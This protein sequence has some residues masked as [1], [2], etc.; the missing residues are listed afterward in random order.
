[1]KDTSELFKEMKNSIFRDLF[2]VT[3]DSKGTGFKIRIGDK[4]K[5]KAV[6]TK[7]DVLNIIYKNASDLQGLPGYA[8]FITVVNE[9]RNEKR[10]LFEEA[11][12]AKAGMIFDLY[13]SEKNNAI[14]EFRKSSMPKGFGT[15]L[16][17]TSLYPSATIN[18]VDLELTDGL[19]YCPKD[20]H[21]Y[22]KVKDNFIRIGTADELREKGSNPIMMLNSLLYEHLSEERGEP[23]DFWRFLYNIADRGTEDYFKIEAVLKEAIT[24]KMP[25][26]GIEVQTFWMK[27]PIELREF[28]K[29]PDTPLPLDYTGR[30]HS[31][32]VKGMVNNGIPAVAMN[33]G[34]MTINYEQQ[35]EFFYRYNISPAGQSKIKQSFTSY[36]VKIFEDPAQL[37]SSIPKIYSVPRIISDIPGVPCQYQAFD[38]WQDNLKDQFEMKDCKIL[39]TFLSP[40]CK[41]EQ[42]AI[43]AWAYTAI[44]PS[45][46]ESIN[47]LFMTGGGTFKTNYYAKMIEILLNLVYRPS[48]SIVHW[49]LRDNWIKD[50]A[51]KENCDGT[52]ISTAALVVNDESTDKCMEEF[53]SMSGGSMDSGMPYQKRVMRENPILIRIYCK[54]LF[55]TNLNFMIQDDS[56]SMDRRIFILKRMDVKKLE[57]PYKA[58]E[59]N[60]M[61]RREIQSFYKFAKQSY[62]YVVKEA[63]SLENYVQSK[64]VFT[65]NLKEAYNEYD[66][67]RLY[68]EF[69]ND[70]YDKNPNCRKDDG[71]IFIKP[72]DLRSSIESM[73]QA[74]GINKEGMMNWIRKTDKCTHENKNKFSARKNEGSFYLLYPVKPEFQKEVIDDDDMPGVAPTDVADYCNRTNNRP[75]VDGIPQ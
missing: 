15:K 20:A 74:Y 3:N 19:Q 27:E 49:M 73:C 31:A 62:E 40:Y 11:W 41:E 67:T 30:L 35:D 25:L 63:G 8:E 28:L 23:F 1:M 18:K 6:K 51:L 66:K 4:D 29:L 53:K 68:I 34:I 48:M 59:Y 43:M 61:L 21:F 32:M 7:D 44:H 64:V 37:I 16:T 5:P 56:G 52:G 10:I 47:F 54:W 42:L 13:I 33:Y 60:I 45:L 55:L 58:G 9:Y 12:K 36:L 57:P 26:D 72:K 50:P 17:P 38:D 70:F 71:S 24:K 46:N 14:E 69:F 2:H 65:K 75:D 22:Y 39:K